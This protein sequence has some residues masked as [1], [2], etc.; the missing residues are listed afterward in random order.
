[1]SANT[2]RPHRRHGLPYRS[3][4][5]STSQ[6]EATPRGNDVLKDT[7]APSSYVPGGFSHYDWCPQNAPT[8]VPLVAT[9]VEGCC[10]VIDVTYGNGNP[11]HGEPSVFT[12]TPRPEYGSSSRS[13]YKESPLHTSTRNDEDD[14]LPVRTDQVGLVSPHGVEQIVNRRFDRIF[15][16]NLKELEN[17]SPVE[18]S[19]LLEEGDNEARSPERSTSTAA[20]HFYRQ[21]SKAGTKRRASALSTSN[22]DISQHDKRQ[23]SSAIPFPSR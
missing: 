20:S 2:T 13:S 23:K 11:H 16:Q 6:F 8:N 7:S 21:T 19:A 17:L 5:D 22:S 9:D 12:S 15:E 10:R 3:E 18:I 4:A 1:M 14:T